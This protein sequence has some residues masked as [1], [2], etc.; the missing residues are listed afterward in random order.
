[1]S[2]EKLFSKRRQIRAAWDPHKMPSKE[3]IY[4]LLKRTQNVSASKQNLFPFKIHAFGPDNL[5]EK[6]IIEQIC[7]LFPTGSVNNYN[8]SEREHQSG[9]TTNNMPGW[10]LVFEQRLA[11]KNKFIK[12]YEKMFE[13]GK[14]SVR[15]T[16]I[17]ENRFRENSNRT[18][19]SIEVGMFTK[20]LAGLCL[21]NDLAI[22]YIRSFPDWSWRGQRKEYQ[23]DRNKVGLSWDSLPQITEAPLLVVQIGYKGKYL[24]PLA[25]TVK[26]NGKIVG[27]KGTP[28]MLE[29]KPSIDEIVQFKS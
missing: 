18:L 24:D 8:W 2:I 11:R 7:C 5:E 14:P 13:D 9:G 4:D 17:D 3:L 23:K 25:S 26:V 29:D 20:I 12:D 28:N 27:N 21:E 15:Y 19:A 22:S 1:M 10:F 16:Q 6:Q